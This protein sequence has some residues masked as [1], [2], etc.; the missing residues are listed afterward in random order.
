MAARTFRSEARI[1]R[2]SGLEIYGVAK[3]SRS[4]TSPTPA[5]DRATGTRWRTRRR[6]RAHRSQLRSRQPANKPPSVHRDLGT[7]GM[8]RAYQQARFAWDESFFE[9]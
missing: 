9:R 3:V 5:S 8:S 4:K 6:C 1:V 2:T 7:R